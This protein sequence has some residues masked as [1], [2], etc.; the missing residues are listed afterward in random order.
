[1]TLTWEGVFDEVFKLLQVTVVHLW[2]D[3]DFSQQRV[4]TAK[5]ALQVLGTPKALE[6]TIDHHC[7]SGAQGLTFLHTSEYKNMELYNRCPHSLPFMHTTLYFALKCILI[8][9]MYNFLACGTQTPPVR[10]DDYGLS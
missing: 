6:L 7:Q 9:I 4:A 10:C 3:V 8:Y 1:M 5:L 2:L